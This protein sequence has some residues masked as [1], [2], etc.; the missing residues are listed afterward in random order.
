M[1]NREQYKAVFSHL[2]ASGDRVQEAKTMKKGH[3]RKGL[4]IGLAAALMV[5]AAGAANAATDGRLFE[6]ARI[7]FLGAWTNEEDGSKTVTGVDENGNEIHF[8]VTPGA[9]AQYDK[10]GGTFYV[11]TTEGEDGV[12]VTDSGAAVHQDE[13]PT[14]YP[15]GSTSTKSGAVTITP[16]GGAA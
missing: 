10:D 14:T 9:D 15:D 8:S 12:L 3:I 1:T 6:E 4:A 7:F 2:H 11:T 13:E 16:A 5:T